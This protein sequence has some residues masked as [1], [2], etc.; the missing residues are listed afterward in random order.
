MEDIE[1]A[2]EGIAQRFE[3]IESNGQQQQQQ[4]QQQ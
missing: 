2:I 1:A 4:Q 3:A